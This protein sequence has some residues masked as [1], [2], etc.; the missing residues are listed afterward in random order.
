MGGV[1]NTPGGGINKNVR[2]CVNANFDAS[3]ASS[4]WGSVWYGTKIENNADVPG[5]TTDAFINCAVCC[6]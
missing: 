1:V 3:T 4:L 5:Y 6:K 2:Q